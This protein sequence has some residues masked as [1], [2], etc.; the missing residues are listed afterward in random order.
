MILKINTFIF[1][2]LEYIIFLWGWSIT[3]T[4]LNK[5]IKCQMIFFYSINNITH[6]IMIYFLMSSK[7][8]LNSDYSYLNFFLQIFFILISLFF[9][10]FLLLMIKFFICFYKFFKCFLTYLILE[11]FT[12]CRKIFCYIFYRWNI[13]DN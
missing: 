7:I 8:K 4:Y 13:I 6:Y 3:V 1:L 11:I 2:I 5:V 9:P 12:G 10:Q